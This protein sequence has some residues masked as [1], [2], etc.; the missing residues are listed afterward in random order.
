MHRLEFS[1]HAALQ[2]E[3]GRVLASLTQSPMLCL[4]RPEPGP[5]VLAEL[6]RPTKCAYRP[7]RATQTA[8]PVQ[9]L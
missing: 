1:D 9:A 7:D 5:G 2:S 3:P 8:L 6:Y 4:L